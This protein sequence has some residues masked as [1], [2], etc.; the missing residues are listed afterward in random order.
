LVTCK[1]HTIRLFAGY[2][3][4]TKE[5]DHSQIFIMRSPFVDLANLDLANNTVAETAFEFE[6]PFINNESYA[7]PEEENL[8]LSDEAD[9]EQT[10]TEITDELYYD[11]MGDETYHLQENSTQQIEG[12]DPG[13]SKEL[14][15][16]MGESIEYDVPK[17]ATSKDI[18]A[19]VSKYFS[20]SAKV[21]TS[22]DWAFQR[23]WSDRFKELVEWAAA[24]VNLNPGLVAANFIAETKAT[25][26]MG[27][28][29]SSFVVGTDDFYDK[30]AD[31]EKKV[32]AYKQIS[33]KKDSAYLT[34]VNERGRTVNT[35]YFK[36]GKDAALASAV[37]LKH[38]E[39]VLR[40]EAAR[41]GKKFDD[42][43]L[44]RCFAFLRLAFNAG[45]GRAKK[46]LNEY[47][48][49][50]QDVLILKP[51]QKAGPQ[52]MATIRTAQAIYLSETFFAQPLN[53]VLKESYV[54][55][56]Q[57]AME[58][59][60]PELEYYGY[61]EQQNN[62]G[63]N[64]EENTYGIT[65]NSEAD[66]E[67]YSV[68]KSVNSKTDFE[69]YYESLEDEDSIN[70]DYEQEEG[71]ESYE[72]DQE[73]L[74]FNNN[75][76]DFEAFFDNYNNEH[77]SN[78]DSKQ[79]GI[80]RNL[81]FGLAPLREFLLPEDKL[82]AL[83]SKYAPI[84]AS[85][86]KANGNTY[87]IDVIFYGSHPEL[88]GRKL[89][90]SDTGLIKEWQ[91]IQSQHERKNTS[92]YLTDVVFYYIHPELRGRQLTKSD[93]GLIQEWNDYKTQIVL[94][95]LSEK[96]ADTPSV[97]TFPKNKHYGFLT[98]QS[99]LREDDLITIQKFEDFLLFYPNRGMV[100]LLM[101]KKLGKET[102]VQVEAQAN[103]TKQGIT[104]YY[105]E[106]NLVPN[107]IGWIKKSWVNIK[108]RPPISKPSEREMK[109]ELQ[110]FNFIRR[111][112]G[113]KKEW[114]PRK[115]GPQ[116]FL[117]K[118]IKGKPAQDG[119]EGTAIELQSE[120]DGYLEFETPK[121]FRNWCELKERIQEAKDIV[122]TLN[123]LPG[124]DEVLTDKKGDDGE[125]MQAKIV[126]FPF[127]IKHLKKTSNNKY[128]LSD[129]EYLEVAIVNPNW[130]AKIQVSEAIELTQYESLLSEHELPNLV[131]FTL[132]R[133]QNILN[134]ANTTK[135][136][137]SSLDNL[138]SFLQ[139][140][141]N[142]IN[143]GQKV[144][145]CK[146]KFVVPDPNNP[147]RTIT[148]ERPCVFPF[149]KGKK[150]VKI[151]RD[152][153]KF[154][155]RLMCRTSFSSIFSSL[156]SPLEQNLFRQIVDKKLILIAFN[157]TDDSPFFINGHGTSETKPTVSKWLKSIV[158][159]IK[160]KDL[161]SYSLASK[162][163]GG[164]SGSEAMGKF[165]V[166]AK[167]DKVKFEARGSVTHVTPGNA[168]GEMIQ[169]ASN[170]VNFAGDVFEKAF[171]DRNINGDKE[172][173]YDPSK[174]P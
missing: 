58:E 50:N 29:I 116:D 130:K 94:P 99:Y 37:C 97:I 142:Y 117:Y 35:V 41:L 68:Y 57:P 67:A 106:G 129:K 104:F 140:I 20:V 25:D 45:N 60:D 111:T 164:F 36:T 87:L 132:L 160:G 131:T 42:I 21:I 81:E 13:I 71:L 163:A 26:Y 137:S 24:Q 80:I 166:K 162:R 27:G 165:D 10:D 78:F 101:E 159:P 149:E 30:R 120:T 39:E 108:Q 118:G 33:W 145:N 169:P 147:N 3:L 32:A 127:D 134:T 128:G 115:F 88:G 46:N 18:A 91:E 155:F 102:W 22:Y 123:A 172:L 167:L 34:G 98:E 141:V 109:F 5:I 7:G 126:K 51:Q 84:M 168:Y 73:E 107:K 157:Y 11:L 17:A 156:L 148:E 86:K 74:D 2:F 55:D 9:F 43:P 143:R 83:R 69:N 28:T 19:Q 72:V 47:F 52:R 158:K 113:K 63:Y 125:P 144:N 1:W 96:P 150:P 23:S 95:Y 170:W 62:G 133:A 93:K 92:D 70:F 152:P 53:L 173:K 66:D 65:S 6:S 90:K 75:E 124:Y 146:G 112:D 44:E 54:P 76:V 171:T 56:Q 174:C 61:R 8:Y 89:T 77:S 122:D 31:L 82:M 153:A 136:P 40:E 38:G 119:N 121:W 139:I 114:L 138:N 14:W 135:L 105:Q 154:T 64:S 12:P 49:K 48:S 79:E 110:T 85:A 103:Y 16:L 100:D 59:N 151:W 161:L 4:A 15:E